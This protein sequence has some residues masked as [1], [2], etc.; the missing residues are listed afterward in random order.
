MA[1]DVFSIQRGGLVTMNG[2]ALR[3]AF[4]VADAHVRIIGS[5]KALLRAR[6]VGMEAAGGAALALWRITPPLR[7]ADSADELRKLA[8]SCAR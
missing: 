4:A 8:A 2:T 3:S 7:L 6:D 5:R 1:S